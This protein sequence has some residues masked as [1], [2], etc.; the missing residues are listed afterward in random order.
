M[1]PVQQPRWLQLAQCH[2]GQFELPLSF[3]PEIER[4]S[5]FEYLAFDRQL[6]ANPFNLNRPQLGIQVFGQWER[7]MKFW[8]GVV[9]GTG[10]SQC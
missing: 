2:V 10:L 9:N 5:S 6:G 7:G 8:A 3:S 1:G 4:L